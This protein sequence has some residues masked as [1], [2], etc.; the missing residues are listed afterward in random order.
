MTV[1]FLPDSIL[2]YRPSQ[3]ACSI[4]HELYR[5]LEELQHLERRHAAFERDILF[6]RASSCLGPL[7]E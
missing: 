5:G 4:V 3:G 6:P 1:R 2:G 7:D